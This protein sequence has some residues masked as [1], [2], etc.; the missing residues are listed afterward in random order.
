MKK[1][2]SLLCFVFLFTLLS[3]SSGNDTKEISPTSSEFSSGELAKLIEVVNEPCELSYSEKEGTI[4]T[5]YIRLKVK[6]KLIKEILEYKKIDAR[7]IDFITLLSV[8]VINLV[9]EDGNNIQDL[10]VKTEELLKLKKLLQADAGS[11]ETIIFE[12]EFHN[13]DDAPKWFEQ[14]VAF[15]PYI[16]GD[17]SVGDETSGNNDLEGV[18][19]MHGAVSKYPVTMQIRINGTNV[20][21]SYY[22]DKQGSDNKL[23]L[24][25]FNNDG[26]LELNETDI[27]GVHTGHFKGE[28]SNGIFKGMF[29]DK[30]GK[31]MP[32]E[33]SEQDASDLDFSSMDVEEDYSFDDNMEDNDNTDVGDASVDEFLEE[34]EEFWNSYISLLKKID[35]D[36][37]TAM[38]EYA[39]MLSK[40]NS[41]N[42]KLQKIRGNLSVSQLNKINNMNAKLAK[43]LQKMK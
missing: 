3:C 42:Q 15:T 39:Q 29:T 14:T 16:T 13:S 4:P 41:Y 32:F 17:V 36:D 28:L 37:P 31:Q 43:E 26:N 19:N 20:K 5:Q 10:S 6:L 9:D 33:F 27:N 24:S 30:N 7:D 2:N 38:V 40:Y 1:L 12:G 21:G 22:Y 23:L 11:T 8:A 25:G 18:H 34:Y 35:K